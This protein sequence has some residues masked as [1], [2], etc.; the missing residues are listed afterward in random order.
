MTHY[1]RTTLRN[2]ILAMAHAEQ[3]R[4]DLLSGFKDAKSISESLMCSGAVRMAMNCIYMLENA[5]VAN[6][7]YE[8]IPA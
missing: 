3:V 2:R 4:G 1:E 6:D 5:E 7:N 8:G